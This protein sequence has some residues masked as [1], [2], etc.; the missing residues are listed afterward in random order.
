MKSDAR[1][2]ASVRV[3]WRMHELPLTGFQRVIDFEFPDMEV[4]S[5]EMGYSDRPMNV[6]FRVGRRLWSRDEEN[7]QL[8]SYFN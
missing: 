1:D 8:I 5:I 6:V 7:R 4:F 3:I 2:T